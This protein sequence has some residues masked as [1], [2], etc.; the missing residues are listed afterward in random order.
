MTQTYRDHPVHDDHLIYAPNH[1][2][3]DENAALS[4]WRSDEEL[5]AIERVYLTAWNNRR[6]LDSAIKWLNGKDYRKEFGFE[7]LDQV[8]GQSW[9]PDSCG[10]VVHQVW[11]HR[12][13][14]TPELIVHH[15]HRSHMICER[16]EGKFKDHHAHHAALLV[17]SRHKEVVLNT[18]AE[19]YQ[20]TRP[21]W[22]FND[23]GHLEIDTTNHPKLTPR[24][25]NAVIAEDFPTHTI[26]VK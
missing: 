19:R 3:G 2:E 17:E 5:T 10:C 4:R 8:H 6:N 23:Q 24:H 7:T 12:L 15:A 25:V 16:H 22:S 13:R 18:V 26:L 9:A 11:D 21:E 14:E 1:N 20:T